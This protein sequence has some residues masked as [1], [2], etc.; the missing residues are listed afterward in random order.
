M[1]EN[2]LHAMPGGGAL[3]VSGAAV[4]RRAG[5]QRCRSGTRGVGMDRAALARIF[6]PY[7]STKAV[8]TGL[9]LTIAK[10]N[11]ELHGGTIT[12]RQRA[13]ARDDGHRADSESTG[14]RPAPAAVRLRAA[15]PRAA[16]TAPRP[17]RPAP[18][19]CRGTRAPSS[20]MLGCS[21]MTAMT[22]ATSAEHLVGPPLLRVDR[23]E[24]VEADRADHQQRRH[25]HDGQRDERPPRVLE[26]LGVEEHRRRGHGGRRRARHAD[27][28]ALV[29]RLD[30]LDVEPRQ[31][32]APPR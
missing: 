23:L 21:W 27:E 1:I 2:A 32:D 9:G 11:V 29:G 3:D 13:R 20:T 18:P 30:A 26:P 25:D 7:F 5:R 6:E 15:P 28:V 4:A 19:A 16:G 17:R 22:S 14:P 12:R 10:R 31:A 24:A 8:G